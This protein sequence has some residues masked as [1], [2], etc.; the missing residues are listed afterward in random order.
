MG[1]VLCRQRDQGIVIGGN[2][3]VTVVEVH[4]GKV[5]LDVSAP[6]SVIVDRKEVHEARIRAQR[7]ARGIHSLD[8]MPDPPRVEATNSTAG[9]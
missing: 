9:A 6:A 8:F 3:E 7:S 1:L 4:G 2:I 5:R